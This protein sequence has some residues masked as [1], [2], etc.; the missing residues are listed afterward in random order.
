MASSGARRLRVHSVD[1]KNSIDPPYWFLNDKEDIRSSQFLELVA[2]EFDIQGLEID[3]ACLVWGADFYIK[4]SDWVYRAFKGTRWQ[5]VSKADKRRYL[6][7]AYRVL[8]TRAR[9]GMIIYVP[10]GDPF[11]ITRKSQFYDGTYRYLKSIGIPE[12]TELPFPDWKPQPKVTSNEKKVKTLRTEP[13]NYASRENELPL[14]FAAEPEVEKLKIGKFVKREMHKLI[15][16]GLLSDNEVERLQR[17]DYS[18]QTFDIQY[19]LLKKALPSDPN[20][21]L[22]Y[23]AGKVL[24]NGRYYFICSEWY[25]NE[26]NNDRP[27][28]MRWLRK[29]RNQQ[30]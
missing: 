20:N 9:Q 1:V 10:E 18:K 3:W 25:E 2:T 22:R 7:N 11:D 19:P 14:E 30:S 15:A 6:K 12:Y 17:A 8:L 16:E 21:I 4:D 23:W 27:Y 28:F 29:I 24:I 26:R 5:R 13:V